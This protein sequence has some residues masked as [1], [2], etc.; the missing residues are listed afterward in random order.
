MAELVASTLGRTA[1]TEEEEGR[2][3]CGLDLVG[4]ERSMVGEATRLPIPSIASL[5]GREED[6]GVR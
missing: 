2:R 1:G 3:A 4:V 5:E 6:E